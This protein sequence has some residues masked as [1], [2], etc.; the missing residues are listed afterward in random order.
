MGRKNKEV[1]H[2]CRN[3][4]LYNREESTCRMVVLHGDEKIRDVPV[5]PGDACLFEQADGDG[6]V[7][8]DAA[9]QV[10]VWAEK[11]ADGKGSVRIE[12]PQGFFGPN[13]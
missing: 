5:D 13:T 7:P 11:S 8:M 1:E 6:F 12:Y 3:C 10:R 9:K 2:V 4:L